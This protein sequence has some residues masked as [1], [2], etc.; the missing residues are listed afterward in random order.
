MNTR[1]VVIN[2]FYCVKC[3]NKGLSLARKK[4][5]QREPGHLKRLF[6][7]KCGRE[8]NHVEVKATGEYTLNHFLAEKEYGNFDEE[9][10]RIVP[11]RQFIG[12]LKVRG[13]F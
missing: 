11:Y 1:G 4:G 10:N 5:Q 3:G 2:D 9:E 6:C 7:L 13:L 8:V 12:D